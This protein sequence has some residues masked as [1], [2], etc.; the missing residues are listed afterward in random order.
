MDILTLI[1]RINYILPNTILLSTRT[2]AGDDS[3][4]M[5]NVTNPMVG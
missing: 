3:V 4:E 2:M 5:L 1:L